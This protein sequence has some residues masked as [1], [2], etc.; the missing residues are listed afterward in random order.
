MIQVRM[1]GEVQ[2]WLKMVMSNVMLASWMVIQEHLGLLDPFQ[3]LA[4][5]IF[6]RFLSCFLY[7]FYEVDAY[8]VFVIQFR[9][10]HCWLGNK[11]QVL[12]CW[13]EFLPCM[14]I[15]VNHVWLFLCSLWIYRQQN[16]TI[17]HL[18]TELD[19]LCSE[20]CFSVVYNYRKM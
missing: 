12:R 3:V 19:C 2:I 1:Q 14:F 16:K 7:K 4:S 6:T 20:I 11:C 15:L 9:L 5:L 10:L 13:V 18:L 17:N 8:Q